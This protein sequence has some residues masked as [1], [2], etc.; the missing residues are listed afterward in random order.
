MPRIVDRPVAV[1]TDSGGRP[2]GFCW[3][4][5]K[6]RVVRIEDVWKEAGRWWAG[7]TE[8][9]FYRVE[10]ESGGVYELYADQGEW[11]LYKIYD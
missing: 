10:A 3:E 5:G 7:E 1:V 2:A 6:R 8:K 11:Y 4:R 9:I